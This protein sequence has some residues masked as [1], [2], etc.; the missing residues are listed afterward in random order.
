MKLPTQLLLRD[1]LKDLPGLFLRLRD[2]AKVQETD[3]SVS[4]AAY[5]LACP[6][7]LCVVPEAAS[8]YSMSTEGLRPLRP[9]SARPDGDLGMAHSLH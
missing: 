5:V 1:V 9:D 2:L 4:A 3:V 6:P 7:L 8:A